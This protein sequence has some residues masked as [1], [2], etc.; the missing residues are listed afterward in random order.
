M[1]MRR[2]EGYDSL[3]LRFVELSLTRCGAGGRSGGITI[4]AWTLQLVSVVLFAIS[5]FET[6]PWV[7]Y[8][9]LDRQSALAHAAAD[10][11]TRSKG[12]GQQHRSASCDSCE[13][14]ISS[15]ED[16]ELY[17]D[18]HNVCIRLWAYIECTG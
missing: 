9:E 18:S 1:C 10:M 15:C 6:V 11:R 4:L 8:R 12:M 3:V 5:L 7:Y 14:A 16:S 17:R 2:Y 13:T